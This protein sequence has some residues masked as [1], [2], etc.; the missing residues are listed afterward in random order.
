[1]R[2]QLDVRHF[3]HCRRES[4]L[5][6]RSTDRSCR[7]AFSCGRDSRSRRQTASAGKVLRRYLMPGFNCSAGALQLV[8]TFVSSLTVISEIVD[9][10]EMTLGIGRS[11]SLMNLPYSPVLRA[12][13][14]SKKSVGPVTL[15][16]QRISGVLR[17]FS[18]KSRPS[19][20]LRL[21]KRTCTNAVT[22]YPSFC[23]SSSARYPVI[24][25]ESSNALRRR[26]RA[27]TGG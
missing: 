4:V 5:V 8:G 2:P 6:S 3:G 26:R 23:L 18:S 1:M 16:H 14:Q 21:A 15:W 24:N 11:C 20:G 13:T 19:L 25:P 10:T 7:V 22:S 17:I 12:T 27:L 9:S